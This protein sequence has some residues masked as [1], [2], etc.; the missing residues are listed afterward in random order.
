MCGEVNPKSGRNRRPS[1]DE[2]LYDLISDLIVRV[3]V[4]HRV[5]TNFCVLGEKIH[6]LRPIFS[7]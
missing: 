2:I 6:G 4:C 5:S 7:W 1:H 3:N